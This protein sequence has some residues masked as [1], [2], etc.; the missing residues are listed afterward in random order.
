MSAVLIGV[1]IEQMRALVATDEKKRAPNWRLQHA[2]LAE[3]ALRTAQRMEDA[4]R[5]ESKLADEVDQLTAERG[6]LMRLLWCIVSQSGGEVSLT[7][8]VM[9][10]ADGPCRIRM[11]SLIRPDDQA[12]VVRAFKEEEQAA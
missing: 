6:D 4:E 7:L 11:Q 5:A 10:Q 2:K 8:D 3:L 9:Q 12:M 1:Y